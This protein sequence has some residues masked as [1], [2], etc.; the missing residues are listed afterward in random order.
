MC[1]T[2]K[3]IICYIFFWAD[4]SLSL[5]LCTDVDVRKWTNCKGEVNT[6]DGTKFIGEWKEGN[7]NGQGNLTYPDGRKYVGEWKN[8]SH[9]GKG[10]FTYPDGAKYL[11][12]IHI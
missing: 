6:P 9:D 11:S 8:G 4:I 5:P 1:H 3:F 10:T 2:Y 12:L 7:P